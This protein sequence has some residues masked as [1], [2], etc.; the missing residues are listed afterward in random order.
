[1]KR[2]DQKPASQNLYRHLYRRAVRQNVYAFDITNVKVRNMTDS[3]K[4]TA[5][6][7]SPADTPKVGPTLQR[8]RQAYNLSLGQ[9]AEQSGVAKSIIAQIEKNETNPT[10]GTLWRLS[11]A[12][13]TPLDKVL[14]EK[15]AEAG[16]PFL[17]MSKAQD[18]PTLSSQDGLC[19]LRI[20][21]WLDT[22]SWVQWYEFR[23]AHGGKLES[24][25]HPIGSVEN[26]TIVEGRVAVTVDG[27]TR[28][29]GAGETLRYA[30]DRPHV[31]EVRSLTPAL[32]I[33]V[34]LVRAGAM[35]A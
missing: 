27:E 4:S 22:V 10:I 28:E 14:A 1:M 30:C 13:N 20:I 26:L 15:E 12:L 23:G 7:R 17:Q 18:T 33:M 19:S 2:D 29:A 9:L 8:L 5:K 34:N 25:G 16:S 21:G 6:N 32:A 24:E 11:Q 3:N 35:T 31:I